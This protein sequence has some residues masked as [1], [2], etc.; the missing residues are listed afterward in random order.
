[1]GKGDNNS[2]AFT[3][4]ELMVVITV[5]AILL[6][7][8]IGTV[9]RFSRGYAF[10]SAVSEVDAVV[11]RARNF[12]LQRQ[13]S[14]LV[15]FKPI[16]NTVWAVGETPVAQLHFEDAES[17]TVSGAFGLRAT[18]HHSAIT[19]GKYGSAREFGTEPGLNVRESY[20]DCGNS[21]AF[22][23][24]GGILIS[25]WIFPGDF[26]G[27]FF[28]SLVGTP[29]PQE[30]RE[31]QSRKEE[32][33]TLK[34][35]YYG[36]YRFT[37]IA[38][39]ASYFLRLTAEYALEFGFL[40][41]RDFYPF[42]TIDRVV[43]PNRWNHVVLR[44]N[45][46]FK[47][48]QDRLKVYVDA[49]ELDIFY[50]DTAGDWK[51]KAIARQSRRKEGLPEKLAKEMLPDRL[52]VSP[53][54]LTISSK[55]ESFFGKIDEVSVSALIEPE[56]HALKSAYLMGYPGTI[57]FDRQGHL[58]SEFHDSA[59]TIMLTENPTY[60]PPE[61]KEEEEEDNFVSKGGGIDE[62]PSLKEIKE[63]R[64]PNVIYPTTT[65]PDSTVSGAN[66]K[67]AVITIS[68]GGTG[69]VEFFRETGQ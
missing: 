47:K 26:R 42:R 18:A 30:S 48:P 67:N 53:E 4:V 3:L 64:K 68:T 69:R 54:P 23:P 21:P 45:P 57:H 59:V 25:A 44:Y 62:P 38:K 33:I 31:S 40:P 39:G 36:E 11:R 27:D 12:A 49:I 17:A 63:E 24:P 35:K 34:Q 66:Y 9:S 6:S 41:D 15:Y 52:Q 28:K 7:I 55:E 37:I 5:L 56:V 19:Q 22:T 14:S 51:L 2:N 50:I 29:K 58:D 65:L 43:T 8:G 32:G 16:G 13:T 20:I 46:V 1:M 60:R 10:E 61:E